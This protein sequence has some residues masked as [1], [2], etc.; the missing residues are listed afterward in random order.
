MAYTKEERQAYD[1]D[2][3]A[4]NGAKK[5][6]QARDWR[7]RNAEHMREWWRANYAANREHILERRRNGNTRRPE[8]VTWTNMK[9]RCYNPAIRAYRWYGARDITVCDRWRNSFANFLADMGLRPSPAHS[10]DR[11]DP[12]GHYT[13][14]NCEWRTKLAQVAHLRSNVIIELN[15]KKQH[16][17]AWSRETGLAE[18]VISERRRRGLPPEQILAAA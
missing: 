16:I 2:Y 6:A 3:R 4:K 5:V 17:A 1:R 9:Q 10:I 13:P 18:R 8:Y 7:H 14:E 11:I 15:G 12:N